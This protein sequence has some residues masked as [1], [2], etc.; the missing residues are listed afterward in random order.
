MDNSNCA[1]LLG[2]SS[3]SFWDT[4]MIASLIS[5]LASFSL[6]YLG[7]RIQA[8]SKLNET[9]SNLLNL[10]IQYPN[11]ERNSFINSI[12]DYESSEEAM[13]YNLYC[14]AWFNHLHELFK[15]HCGNVKKIQNEFNCTE[16]VN[17][18]K[19]W[20]LD[21]FKENFD[22]YSPDFVKFIQTLIK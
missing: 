12:T 5:I 14:I 13:R 9:L 20:W 1:Q 11:L 16:I 21:N 7:N 2:G 22:G 18:H 19:K 6:Y 15:F 3:L 8:K 4:T 10:G 17:T